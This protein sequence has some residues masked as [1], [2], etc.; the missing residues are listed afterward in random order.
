MGGERGRDGRG[1]GM[2]GMRGMR[3]EGRQKVYIDD[4]H[5]DQDGFPLDMDTAA[6]QVRRL[7]G[8][9]EGRGKGEGVEKGCI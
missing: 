2:R 8:A 6:S 9:R 4:G 1:R 7:T 3:D 5:H